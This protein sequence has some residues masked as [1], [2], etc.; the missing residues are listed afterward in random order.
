MFI[1]IKSSKNSPRKTV[2]I[3]ENL[4]NGKS[5][6]QKTVRYIG[7]ANDDDELILLKQ[8]AQQIKEKM[9]NQAKPSL[10]SADEL[11]RIKQYSKK[12]NS[13]IKINQDNN[14]FS[15]DLKKLKEQARV[16]NGI[17]E[18]Y[19]A[20][21]DHLGF[22]T[23]F[24]EKKIR[25]EKIFKE[26][27]LAR[28]ASPKSK[29]A[30]IKM[31]QRSFGVRLNVEAVYRM[32]DQVDEKLIE[33]IK[34]RAY[35]ETRSLF[36]KKIDVIFF[37][38]T[39]LYYESFKEDTFRK[40]GYSK[41]KKFNQ[42]QILLALLVS[43]EG[44]PISYEVFAGNTYEGHTLIPVIDGVRKKYDIEKVILV[45]DSGMFN[46]KNLKELEARK[47]EYIVGARLRSQSQE[48]S[49]KIL[50]EKGYVKKGS[51]IKTKEIRHKMGR[52]IVSHSE[53]RAKK[54]ERDR[55]KA[56][57]LLLKKVR[58]DGSIAAKSLVSNYGYKKYI[59][60]SDEDKLRV[61][62]SKL[63]AEKQWDGLH[64]IITNSQEKKHETILEQYQQLWQ[65]EDAFRLQKHDLK[66]RPIFHFKERRIKA[67][68]A[69]LFVAFCIAKHMQYRVRH[70]YKELSV[71]RIKEELLKV[72]SSI[73][74]YEENGYSYCMPGKM[75]LEAEK[76]YG[77]IG[78]K[79]EHKVRI[80]KVKKV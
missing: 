25:T 78:V 13:L 5:V 68:V 21:Y 69:I 66:I 47:I 9:E 79:C 41:D 8:L 57:E 19:G 76:I 17:H 24:G 3:V 74:Y 63:A 64:G 44:M 60:I 70:Q 55:S 7:V 22:N 36:P 37:D 27:V 43:K 2:Q 42:P 1:R 12:K 53:K 18:A 26:M 56:I 4:R 46:E 11:M 67:H 77:V 65:I 62:E 28:L 49:E 33:N 14:N 54:D 59:K 52:M 51:G 31:L 75:S 61:D 72:Q 48:I 80:I 30:S 50:E 45:A 23:L 20:L 71:D 35:Q 38:T 73:Y 39:T 15:V 10:F 29:L 58:K 32:M 6:I 34:E 16:I 40:N